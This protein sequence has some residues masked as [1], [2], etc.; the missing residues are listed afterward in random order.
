MKKVNIP[1]DF[2]KYVIASE[3]YLNGERVRLQFTNG[4]GASV[5][6]HDVSYGLE[7]AVLYKNNLC[8][9]TDITHDVIGHLNQEELEMYLGRI[10]DL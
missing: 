6:H 4:Y 7:L 2:K 1:E 8:Y 3:I 5:I 9:S 10:K